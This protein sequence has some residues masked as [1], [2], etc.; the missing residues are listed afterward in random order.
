M[1]APSGRHHRYIF[2]E[3]DR[4]AKG[5]DGAKKVVQARLQ[6]RREVDAGILVFKV[7]REQLAGGEAT[8]ALTRH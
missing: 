8:R 3:K 1:F 6:V 5:K 7:C 2:E 4:K